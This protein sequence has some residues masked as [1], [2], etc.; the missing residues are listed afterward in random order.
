MRTEWAVLADAQRARIF[1][2]VGNGSWQDVRSLTAN[3]AAGDGREQRLPEA[4]QKLSDGA[5]NGRG[6]GGFDELLAQELCQA[7]KRGDFDALILVAP[8]PVLA[9]VQAALDRATRRTLRETAADNLAALPLRDARR[10]IA[11]RFR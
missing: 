2:R 8:E 5:G 11:R 10:E 3:A 6:N 7:R 4:M 9:A 1:A